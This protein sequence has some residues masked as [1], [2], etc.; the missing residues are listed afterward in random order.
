[1]DKIIITTGHYQSRDSLNSEKPDIIRILGPNLQKDGYWLT[2]DGKSMP[3]YDLEA[4]WL[5]LDTASSNKQQNKPPINIFA[6]IGEE[7]ENSI[8]EENFEQQQFPQHIDDLTKPPIAPNTSIIIKKEIPFDISIIEKINIDKLNLKAYQQ[9]GITNKYKKPI[10]DIT[11]PISFNY[12]I[13][14][15]KQTIELLELNEDIIL[16][17][18]V[19]EIEISTIRPLIKEKLK[20]KF[21]IQT[22][23][24]DKVLKSAEKIE[25]YKEIK[26]E[27]NIPTITVQK[28]SQELEEN[29]E[30]TQGISEVES[31]IKKH[32]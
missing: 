25:V 4:N 16:D 20:Q 24:Y 5:K 18:L 1:M 30:L 7:D 9:F 11:L 10:I 22:E 12:D 3:S 15:L 19:K 14:K 27:E 23:L 28:I 26:N 2:Q 32:F 8:I 29:K 31:Y 17:Y 6:G 13:I 21:I